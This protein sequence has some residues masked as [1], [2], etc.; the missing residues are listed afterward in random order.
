[1]KLLSLQSENESELS[2]RPSASVCPSVPG[3]EG[4]ADPPAVSP[5]AEEEEAD[6]QEEDHHRDV[7]EEDVDRGQRR[8]RHHG[9]SERAPAHCTVTVLLLTHSFTRASPESTDIWKT[10]TRTQKS[11][12]CTHHSCVQLAQ[13]ENGKTWRLLHYLPSILRSF[14]WFISPSERLN[15][16]V[17][18]SYRAGNSRMRRPNAGITQPFIEKSAPLKIV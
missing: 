5:V 18:L 4:P 3:R 1:M 17:G 2:A 9:A 14:S 10:S 7:R 15:R 16:T 13:F 12:R 11:L 6:R 8:S